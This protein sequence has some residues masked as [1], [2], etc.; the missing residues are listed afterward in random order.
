MSDN[1]LVQFVVGGTTMMV[2]TALANSKHKD[3]VKIAGILSTIPL[4][5]MLPV[6]FVQSKS[7]GEELALSNALSNIG[8]M[9]AMFLLYIL[10]Q[11]H[12]RG[13]SFACALAVWLALAIVFNLMF[14]R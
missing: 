7:K 8:V 10:L 14:V 6:L 5:D 13:V 3:M 2:V 9:I 4:L 12:S 1:P 11:R